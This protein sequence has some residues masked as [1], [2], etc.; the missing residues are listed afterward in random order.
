MAYAQSYPVDGDGW[1]LVARHRLAAAGGT[2]T[3]WPPGGVF[4]MNA[5]SPGDDM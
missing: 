4:R 2:G 1:T 5:D 3:L